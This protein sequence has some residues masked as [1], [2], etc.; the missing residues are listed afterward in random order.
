MKIYFETA[1][2]ALFKDVFI[3]FKNIICY[4]NKFHKRCS[5]VSSSFMKNRV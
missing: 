5:F 4:P 3:L 2:L 1:N